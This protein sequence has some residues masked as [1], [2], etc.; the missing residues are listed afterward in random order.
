MLINSDHVPGGHTNTHTHTHTHTLS[1]GNRGVGE[2]LTE[3]H[4]A[5]HTAAAKAPEDSTADTHTACA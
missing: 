4:A 1:V 2:L 5:A 3:S